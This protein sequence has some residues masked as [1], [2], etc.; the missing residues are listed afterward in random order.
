M[1]EASIGNTETDLLTRGWLDETLRD[2]QWS[3][4]EAGTMIELMAGYGRNFDSTKHY[5]KNIEM[6][7]GSSE[8][9]KYIPSEVTHHLCKLEEFKWP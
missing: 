6:L 8:M 2:Q 7:D 9:S 3:D 5:F 1:L 4:W